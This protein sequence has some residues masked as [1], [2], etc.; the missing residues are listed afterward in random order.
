[1]REQMGAQIHSHTLTH[2]HTTDTH[3][4][5]RTNTH[6]HTPQPRTHA[7]TGRHKSYPSPAVKQVSSNIYIRQH[8]TNHKVAEE[9]KS[10]RLGSTLTRGLKK[11]KKKMR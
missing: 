10:K 9:L 4:H 5:R 2:I 6:T 8:Q 1:M 11:K 3:T 7:F